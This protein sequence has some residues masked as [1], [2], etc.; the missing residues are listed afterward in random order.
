MPAFLVRRILPSLTFLLHEKI[1]D[2]I[3]IIISVSLATFRIGNCW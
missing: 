3:I 2:I 1:R